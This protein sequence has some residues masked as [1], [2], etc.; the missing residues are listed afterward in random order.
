MHRKRA[1]KKCT[2]KISQRRNAQNVYKKKMLKKV[3]QEQVNKKNAQKKCTE[4][5]TGKMHKK[6]EI[7]NIKQYAEKSAR[8][9]KCT[10]KMHIK[11]AHSG[12]QPPAVNDLLYFQYCIVHSR[13]LW[14]I[15]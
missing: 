14:C 13:F 2:R 10:Q 11:S 6:N 12:Q 3:L 5:S 7:K 9:K 4:N 1:Q 15:L 8:K